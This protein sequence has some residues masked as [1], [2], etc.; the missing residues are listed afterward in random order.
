MSDK[1]LEKQ[2]E[3]LLDDLTKNWTQEQRNLLTDDLS[4]TEKLSIARK[5]V[6]NPDMV[7]RSGDDDIDELR[8]LGRKRAQQRAERTTREGVDPWGQE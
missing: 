4:T 1:D 5:V 2:A 7:G 3:A 8:E 6:A